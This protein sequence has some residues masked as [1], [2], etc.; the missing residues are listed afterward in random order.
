MNV[1]IVLLSAVDDDDAV[2][3]AEGLSDKAVESEDCWKFNFWQ[4]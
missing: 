4:Q 3:C 1:L 2:S